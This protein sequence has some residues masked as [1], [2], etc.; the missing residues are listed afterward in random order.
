M[1]ECEEGTSG[2]LQTCSNTNG[3]YACGC[4]PG[5]HLKEEDRHACEGEQ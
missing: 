4:Y 5:Y 2:C 1:N 3:S